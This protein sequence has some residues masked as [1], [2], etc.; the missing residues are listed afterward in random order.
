MKI[1]SVTMACGDSESERMSELVGIY[2]SKEM[3][4]EIARLYCPVTGEI[5]EFE[6]DFTDDWRSSKEL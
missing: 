5:D 6:L 1:Y 4:E 3:A 2:S